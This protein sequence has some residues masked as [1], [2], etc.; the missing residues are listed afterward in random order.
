MT[1]SRCQY[2]TWPHWQAGRPHRS[3]VWQGRWSSP[4]GCPPRWGRGCEVLV[5][6]FWLPDVVKCRWGPG[7]SLTLSVTVKLGLWH[8]IALHLCQGRSGLTPKS[9][10]ANKSIL[11][12]WIV[13][14]TRA[15]DCVSST[16]QSSQTLQTSSPVL[17][18]TAGPI[19]SWEAWYSSW[20]WSSVCL[21]LASQCCNA[22]QHAK[23]SARPQNTRQKITSHN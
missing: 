5:L 14:S 10:L 18:R 3:C 9:L 23:H 13:C 17:S 6:R 19:I 7:S 4:L 2:R 8:P 16:T 15:Y 12:P 21:S 1:Y 11:P 20:P 22:K